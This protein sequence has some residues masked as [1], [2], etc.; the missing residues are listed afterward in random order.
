LPVES[1]AKA[2]ANDAGERR[3]LAD[4]LIAQGHQA[5]DSG[6]A[7]AALDYYKSACAAA[8]DYSRAH[9]NRG[10]ALDRLNRRE[11][12]IAAYREALALDPNYAPAH[13]NLG[14]LFTRLNSL[15]AAE[16]ELRLALAV[17]PKH[18]DAIVALADVLERQG[19]WMGAETELR[20]ALSVEPRHAGALVNIGSLLSATRRFDEAEQF[21]ARACE[22]D[23]DNAY[24][25]SALG[26]AYS[27]QR[28]AEKAEQ[29]FRRA[30]AVNDKLPDARSGLLFSLNFRSDLT[31]EQV[32]EAHRIEGAA[33]GQLAPTCEL[34][35]NQSDPERKLRVGYVSGDL[36]QH[37]VGLFLRPVLQHHD[38]AFIETFCYHNKAALTPLT[39]AL[40]TTS[41]HWRDI[42]ALEDREFVRLI[43]DDRI[44]ILVDLSGHTSNNRLTAFAAH[45]APVQVSWIAYLNTTGLK[46]MDWRICDAHTD[47]PGETEHL[48]VERLYRMPHS[49]WC[50]APVVELPEKRRPASTAGEVVFG[51]F[52]QFAKISDACLA[53]WVEILHAVPGSRLIVSNAPDG[54]ARDRLLDHVARLRIEPARVTFRERTDIA[55]YFRAVSDVDIA[56]D[57]FPY[58]GATTTLDALWM[59][60]PLVALR[61][62]RGIARSSY[63]I[64]RSAGLDQL[65]AT[66]PQECVDINVRLARDPDERARLRAC[67]RNQLAASPLM[68]APS[69]VKALESAYRTMW[70]D[71]CA[72]VHA[73][74]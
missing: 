51:S 40:Q 11:E 7:G 1:D 12:A 61:G 25:Q 31:P 14:L 13:V 27:E 44:D 34:P 6:S 22:I 21:L 47:P 64:L 9:L 10:N 48:H 43:C 57:T 24:A 23:P 3:S 18:A 5:E 60:V 66:T 26:H 59:G 45:P 69:F 28:L 15:S 4:R 53:L 8:P 54:S 73:G 19:N 46:A 16:T 70:R 49:Q 58:N 50:Y 56:L 67:L 2:D 68:D 63:S 32:F 52:N 36:G 55:N 39:E 20:R 72:R 17:A 62:D 65:I 29:A 30:L 74:V 37:P 71:W 35:R 42:F 33:I 38:R 41:D